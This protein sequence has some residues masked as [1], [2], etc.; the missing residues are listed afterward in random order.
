[1]S[2]QQTRRY[3]EPTPEPERLLVR[4]RPRGTRVAVPIAGALFVVLLAFYLCA[5]FDSAFQRWVIVLAAAVILLLACAPPILAWGSIRYRITNRRILARRGS[6]RIRR[7]ELA[8][9][10][11]LDVT[12]TRSVGQRM[13]RCGDVR[14]AR[15]GSA[16]FVLRDLPDPDLVAEVLREA[17]AASPAPSWP[18][19]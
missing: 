4:L 8:F 7:G 3:D 6:T 13:T 12:V 17:I 16:L 1:M 14:V 18:T 5:Q 10:Q 2:E 11:G 15:D 19:V 9:D